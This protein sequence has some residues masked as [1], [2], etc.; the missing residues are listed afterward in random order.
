MALPE[1]VDQETW[2]ERRVALLRR[3]KELTR[4]LDECAAMR[5]QLPMVRID[6]DYRF[7]GA[8]GEVALIDLFGDHDQLIVQH[9]MFDPEWD[10]GCCSCT[11]MA[12]GAAT[13]EIRG[14]LEGRGTAFAA[15]SR[16]PFDKLAAVRRSHG[17]TFDWYSS[18]DSDF[19]YDFGVTIDPDVL[20]VQFNFHTADELAGTNL[21]WLLTYGGEQPGISCFLRDGDQVFRTYST[22]GRGLESMMPAYHLLDLTPLGRQ[23]HWERPAGRAPELFREDVG[24]LTMQKG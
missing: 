6:K 17:W 5:R 11:A 22:Y 7:T 19:N 18:H 12:T 20:P 8:H 23:E 3:E 10:D 14:Q 9:F 4:Q 24:V 21:E 1:I 15:V 16:A 2:L 13:E